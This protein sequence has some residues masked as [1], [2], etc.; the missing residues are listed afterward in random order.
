[1]IKIFKYP[2]TG[3]DALIPLDAKVLHVAL[4]NGKP[5]AWCEVDPEQKETRRIA[6][7]PTDEE[8][9]KSNWKHIGSVTGIDGWMVW[10]F[11]IEQTGVEMM[12]ALIR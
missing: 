2:L 12:M 3:P 10:H 5:F 6:I 1:M 7:V 11:Y 4:Q 8:R 9:P